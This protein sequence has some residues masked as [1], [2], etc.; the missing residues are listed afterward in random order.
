M[1][2]IAYQIYDSVF[3][4]FMEYECIAQTSMEN[5]DKP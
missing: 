1:L 5:G 2:H 4:H 3:R